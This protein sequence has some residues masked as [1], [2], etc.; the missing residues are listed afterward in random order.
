MRGE[1]ETVADAMDAVVEQFGEREAYV[2]G[3]R[4]VT[5]AD[6]LSAADRLAGAL[7]ERGRRPGRRGRPPAAPIH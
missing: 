1:F 5:F 4:R 7:A 2:E 3:T 6:W